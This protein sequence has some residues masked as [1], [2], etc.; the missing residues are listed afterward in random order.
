MTNGSRFAGLGSVLAVV[1]LVSVSRAQTQT[2]Q[3]QTQSPCRLFQLGDTVTGNAGP[4]LFI[5][6][7]TT[8]QW[9]QL[10]AQA[11]RAWISW[12]PFFF[13]LGQ[14]AFNAW[15]QMRS[16]NQQAGYTSI[17]FVV[18]RNGQVTTNPGC[19]YGVYAQQ[20]ASL[21]QSLAPPPFPTGSKLQSVAV[22]YD[23]TSIVTN[24]GT[25][26]SS[27]WTQ[28]HWGEFNGKLYRLNVAP[29]ILKAN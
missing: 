25:N 13:P 24:P 14:Q 1:L 18:S 2:G 26:P 15:T 21:V 27:S 10:Q 28:H 23:F 8:Q 20:V 3:T 19:A 5:D 6:I 17:D 12:D 16:Q 29:A 9:Q 11:G 4:T 7:S 22:N